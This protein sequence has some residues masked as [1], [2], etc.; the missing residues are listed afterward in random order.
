MSNA[1]TQQLNIA[2]IARELA[3]DI[4]EPTQTA[5]RFNLS[6]PELDELTLTPEFQ[7]IFKGMVMDWNAAANTPERI[8][9]KAATAVEAALDIFFWDI[10]DRSNS[11]AQRVEAMKMLMKLGE[12]GE[13]D[14]LG[15]GMLGGVT[16]NIG[17]G[18]PGEGQ[19]PHMV[20][21]EGAA[22]PEMDPA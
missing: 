11:L 3:S 21:I 9:V 5:K 10:K 18:A 12:L 2:A 19:T 14:A 20:T 4:F 7:K 22:L 16:I 15:G 6:V 17:M 8:K 13:K 1:I